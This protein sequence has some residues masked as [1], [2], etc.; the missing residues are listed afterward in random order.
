MGVQNKVFAFFYVFLAKN[1]VL[2]ISHQSKTNK[3]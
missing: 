2:I 1:D 3:T